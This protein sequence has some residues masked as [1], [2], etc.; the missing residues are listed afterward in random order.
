VTPKDYKDVLR[1]AVFDNVGLKV[2]SILCAL[3][4]YGFVHGSENAQRTFRVS[5][6]WLMPPE[7]ANRELMTQIPTEVNVTLRGSRTQLDDLRADDLGSLQLDLRSGRETRIN[8]DPAMFH[9]PGGLTVEQIYPSLFELR[10]D[11]VITRPIPIQVPRTG[12]LPSGL[13]VKGTAS[14]EP[15]TVNARGPRSVV[16]VIQFARTAPFD[17]TGLNEG[18]ERR[19]LPVDKP[20][21]LV[22]YDLESVVATLEVSRENVTREFP[23]K[24]QVV[25]I[26]RAATTPT[27]VMVKV[28]GTSDAIKGLLQES[29]IPRVEPKMDAP[30]GSAYLDVLVDVPQGVRANI[31][32][33]KVLV[34]W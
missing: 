19:S 32:P 15:P 21:Q 14:V 5:V 29:I 34:R 25:G 8:L 7:S 27:T 17:V 16:E 12:E 24:V 6:L 2:I 20:P 1:G 4:I 33:P 13:T 3:L 31:E 22:R 9:V 28:T 18:T 26:P 30:S 11:D 23:M 10:W